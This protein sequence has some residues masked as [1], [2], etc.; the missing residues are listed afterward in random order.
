MSDGYDVTIGY[1][2]RAVSR[3]VTDGCLNA[4]LMHADPSSSS[5]NGSNDACC[6]DNDAETRSFLLR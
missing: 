4:P 1:S 2:V 5:S 6:H 3:D